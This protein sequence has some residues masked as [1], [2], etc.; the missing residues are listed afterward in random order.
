MDPAQSPGLG[1]CPASVTDVIQ[2]VV[3][4]RR[5]LLPYSKRGPLRS[6]YGYLSLVLVL[7]AFDHDVGTLS[8]EPSFR[9]IRC[10]GEYTQVD[11]ISQR[12]V[13]S[14]SLLSGSDREH[15]KTVLITHVR[16]Q[17]IA[18]INILTISPWD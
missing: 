9:L 5:S 6:R 18:D 2:R 8:L 15:G 13:V 3:S 16:I 1:E 4:T 12:A 17:R 7:S 10:N 11:G 14:A